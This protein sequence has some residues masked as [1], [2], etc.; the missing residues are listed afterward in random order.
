MKK[1]LAI[2][3]C[4][5]LLLVAV[6][7]SAP[8]GGG[9]DNDT[10]ANP[11][12][13]DAVVWSSYADIITEYT[14]LLEK[15]TAEEALPE[16]SDSAD[17]ITVALFEIVRDTADPSAMGYATK[18]VN[19]DGTEELVLL[20]RGNKLYALFTLRGNAPVLLLKADKIT[21]AITPDGTVY[22][23]HTVKNQSQTTQIKTISN[24]E[25]QGLE[26]GSVVNGESVTKYK[27]E[28]GVKTD[29]TDEELYQ[30]YQSAQHIIINPMYRTKT[31]GF[32]FV[33]A[34]SAASGDAPTPNFT[35]Y[36]GIISAYRTIV[37]GMSEYKQLDWT[38]GAFD[39]LFTISDNDSY[40]VFH[41]IF[42]A[43]ARQMPTE[44]PFGQTY[45][46]DGD[47]SYGYAT[48]DLNGDGAD[49]LILLND[50]YEILALFTEENGRIRRD[51]ATGGTVDRD[52]EG[53]VYVLEGAELAPEIAV[54]YR[55]NIY[56]EKEG[57]YKIENGKKIDISAQEGEALYAA[58]DI[59]PLGYSYTEYTRTFSGIAFVP[60]F[61]AT[62]AG[63]THVDTF[64][65]LWFI[66]GNTLTVS[67]IFEDGVTATVKFVDS[68]GEFD[69]ETNPNP[70]THITELDVSAIR[71]GNRYEFEKDGV[72]GYLE[73]A[74]HSAWVVVT[75]SQN[76]HVLCR[77]YLFNVPQN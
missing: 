61:E 12:P 32:R 46:A 4:L 22:T 33:S 50:N 18:D 31:T 15:R 57:W 26:F 77:A 29:I 35:S 41:Q 10:T 49:E 43:C 16:P 44:T 34:L 13:S 74:V 75:E 21:A 64:A 69:P 62:R 24:G 54:G 28:N 7:C 73:F 5:L 51:A 14:A 9:G 23:N 25:L 40:D 52:G 63:Q 76:E 20:N 17:E 55:V 2:L 3:L 37:E 72:K 47:N 71:N 58:Y 27:L 68:E 39:G 65:N 11:D 53:Y 67:E 59:L 6:S 36:D 38:N 42:W 8:T 66:N 70:E 1:L 19:G 56:L 60:L 45:A 48:R 30:L